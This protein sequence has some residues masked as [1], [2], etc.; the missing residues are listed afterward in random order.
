MGNELIIA[1]VPTVVTIL[2]S[3]I[4]DRIARKRQ[5]GVDG[6]FLNLVQ[7]YEQQTQEL[8]ALKKELQS[9]SQSLQSLTMMSENINRLHGNPFTLEH[10]QNHDFSVRNVSSNRIN[11]LSANTDNHNV[12][13][14]TTVE[15]PKLL[16]PQDFITI[17]V[18]NTSLAEAKHIIVRWSLVQYPE[19][20]HVAKLELPER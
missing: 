7:Q 8:S 19:L 14:T 13:T 16:E 4:G 20:E 18:L 6:Q 17:N 2:A 11:V 10:V 3:T 1:L 12:R 9:M 15:F 5:K